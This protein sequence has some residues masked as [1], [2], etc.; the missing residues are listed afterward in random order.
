MSGIRVDP[1]R[2]YRQH[3]DRL[4][5]ALSPAEQGSYADW[6]TAH[7]ILKGKPYSYGGHEYQ[8]TILRDGAR[9]KS[10]RKPSQVGIS[11]LSIR[12]ALA[13][14]LR[15][16]G[17]TMMYV[18]PTATFSQTFAKTRFDVVVDESPDVSTQRHKGT[19]SSSVKRFLN[20]SFVF[21]KGAS[22]TGQAI[23]VPVDSL[24]IDE[25]D[26][27]EDQDILSQFTSRLTHSSYKEEF[28]LSTPTVPG[29]GISAHY[30]AALQFIE[31][32][33]CNRCGHTFEPDYYRDVVVPGLPIEVPELNYRT[34]TKLEGVDLAK[35]HLACPKCRRQVA[36]EAK[37]RK[38][39]PFNPSC[40]SDAHAYQVTPF[41]CPKTRTVGDVVQDSVKY[42]QTA[43]FVNFGL[44]LP[45]ESSETQLTLSEV[46]AAFDVNHSLYP[47]E[48]PVS[49]AGMDLGGEC[50]HLTGGV[51]VDNHVR[52]YS[53]EMIP[54]HQVVER[55]KE[56]AAKRRVISSVIDMM[57][58]TEVVRAVQQTDPNA[59]ACVFSN[60]K[61]TTELFQVKSK[62]EDQAKASFGLRQINA[63][64][65]IGLDML[66][67]MLKTGQISFAKS[68]HPQRKLITK[69]L[70]SLK[71]VRVKNRGLDG[72]DS[73][74]WRKTDGEDHYFFALLYLVL[75]TYLRGVSVG[76]VPLP[77]LAA[78][79]R[80]KKFNK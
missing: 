67:D 42:R 75:A 22:R 45:Y 4:R 12:R 55:Y 32:T 43:D 38:F 44:G 21:F 73:F 36:T 71:R 69:H 54:L 59:F 48:A 16:P 10:V 25:V 77:F 7:T 19:D 35:A 46:D 65:H 29:Y 20:N 17:V 66:V 53:A 80:L 26:L 15:N 64:R 30:E 27:A 9:V 14:V 57:P 3:I 78:P 47:E 61:I 1:N 37:Y 70:L 2:F 41:S 63:N 79:M 68:C 5:A 39:V 6:V 24:V 60:S 33:T 34:R 28:Y 23:S 76:V 31:L 74:A 13:F 18:L 8:E 11:E 72:G 58:Y 56:V 40:K 50:A 52:V 51:F 62:E 49:V